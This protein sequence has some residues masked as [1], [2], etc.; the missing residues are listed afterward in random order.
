VPPEATIWTGAGG[1]V[2]VYRI[3]GGDLVNIV[4][5]RETRDWLEE[6]WSLKAHAGELVEAFPGVHSDL[7]I[8]LERADKCFKWG[9][10]DRQPLPVWSSGRITLL[11][12]AAHPMLPFLGQGA[13]MTI[14]DSYVLAW[15]LERSLGDIPAAFRAYES[16][17][18]PRTTRTQ[19][20]ARAQGDIF[21][22]SRGAPDLNTDWL[23]G[24]VPPRA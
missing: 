13:A 15:A 7:R 16:E 12:D 18:V 14:E 21:H 8:I 23:Y 9:L 4:A 22:Q 24:Y 2:V 17:R 6:S 3:R 11:G 5:V 20:A 1:H 10:F 19:L